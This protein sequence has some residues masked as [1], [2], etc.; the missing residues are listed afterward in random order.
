MKVPGAPNACVTVVPL[1]GWL[2]SPKSHTVELIWSPV[3]VDVKVAGAPATP[4]SGKVKS[5]LGSAAAG[6]AMASV[7]RSANSPETGTAL[8][9]P[10]TTSV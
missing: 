5:A 10:W 7:S 1:A 9:N 6:A 4:V 3:E 2:P 8:E